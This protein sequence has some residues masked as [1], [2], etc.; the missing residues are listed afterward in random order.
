ME[1]GRC[2]SS[3]TRTR[4]AVRCQEYCVGAS[5][6]PLSKKQQPASQVVVMSVVKLQVL[7]EEIEVVMMRQ[8]QRSC[9]G[10]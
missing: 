10:C 7:V 1:H 6:L 8:R 9:W 4:A 5:L 3:G 2:E